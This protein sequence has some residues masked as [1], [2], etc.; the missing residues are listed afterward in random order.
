MTKT[1]TPKDWPRAKIKRAI[2]SNGHTL[3]G[4]SI[5]YGY[6][7]VDAFAQALQRPYPKIEKLIAQLLGLT[8]ET[9]WPSRYQGKYSPASN[10]GNVD[11]AAAG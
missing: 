4:L 10:A 8:P 2:Y 3:K 11:Q 1:S 7:S 6:R 9:I 5:A